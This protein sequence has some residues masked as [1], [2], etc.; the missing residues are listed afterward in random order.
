MTD[1]VLKFSGDPFNMEPPGVFAEASDRLSGALAAMH[2]AALNHPSR[3]LSLAITKAEEATL[4]LREAAPEE[5]CRECGQRR[6]GS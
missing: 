3:A 2:D 5:W 1:Q 4:W 6:Q